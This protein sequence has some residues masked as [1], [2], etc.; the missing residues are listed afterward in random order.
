MLGAKNYLLSK[1]LWGLLITLTGTILEKYGYKI[2]EDESAFLSSA[3]VDFMSVLFTFGGLILAAIGR[4][5]ATKVL[6]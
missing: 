2:S 1:T 4:I 5:K 6:K 3:I